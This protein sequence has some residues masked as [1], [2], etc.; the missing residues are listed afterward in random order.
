MLLDNLGHSD[1]AEAEYD[2]KHAHGLCTRQ[3]FILMELVEDESGS[4]FQDG[5]D[6]HL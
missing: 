2:L 4:Q 1:V 3:N 6:V 5:V